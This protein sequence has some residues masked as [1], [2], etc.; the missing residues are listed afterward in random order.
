MSASNRAAIIN[1]LSKVLKKHFQPVKPPSD[2]TVLEH[3]LYACCLENAD[4]EQADEAFA[5]LQ[6]SYF[7]WNEV[8][9]TTVAELTESMG[10]LPDPAAAAMRLKSALHAVFEGQYSFDL[11]FLRKENLGKAVSRLEGYKGVTPFVVAYVS[12]NGLNGHAIPIDAAAISLASVID[13]ITEKEAEKGVV[14]GL[15]RAIPKT[16]GVE[17][18]SLFH[19]LAVE[20]HN[21]PF[22][23]EV[24]KIV[25]EI[26]PDAKDRFPKRGGK[27]T[28]EAEAEQGKVTKSASKKAAPKKAAPKKETT[29]KPVASKTTSKKKA[30]TK[31]P[32]GSVKKTTK[33]KSIVK[34]AGPRE[35]K[36]ATKTLA[37]KK[38]R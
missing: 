33:K 15:E 6:E 14:P 36:S 34:S 24:R 13:L 12:Q 17:F 29:K 1:K 37:R 21:G 35:K 16:K 7:D 22:K 8:R 20:Y 11:D 26:D 25:L 23:P 18:A 28:A 3:L 9:V 31:K 19:K 10:C 5:R 27:K 4:F 32:A 2:R 38:P 30:A